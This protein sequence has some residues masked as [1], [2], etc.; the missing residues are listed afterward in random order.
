MI[1]GD[2]RTEPVQATTLD[3]LFRRTAARR[4]DAIALAD[5][6]DRESFT[7]GPPRRLT[8]AETDRIVS[9]IATRLRAL[10]L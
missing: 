1:L 9:A 8:Y 2:T 6:P 3:D 7:D 4:P 10:G 5:P